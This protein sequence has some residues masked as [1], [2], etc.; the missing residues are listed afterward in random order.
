M[1]R[2]RLGLAPP[3]APIMNATR[4]LEH[5]GVGV[6]ANLDGLDPPSSTDH[7]GISMPHSSTGRPPL[8]ALISELSGAEQRFAL[9]H[10]LG[11]LIFDQGLS[12]PIR[13]R[14][15]PA[16]L[17]AHHFARAM[18][19]PIEAVSNRISETLNLQGYL[20]IKAEFGVPVASIIK[21]GGR[22]LGLISTDRERSLFIQWSSQGWRKNEPSR[23]PQRSPPSFSARR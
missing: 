1:T 13:T 10:E 16:E 21:R 14:R 23:W 17:R 18:L 5:L 4:T 7:M 19:L 3:G 15:H 9:M 2:N 8:V 6:V 20:G 12:A 11:H 22:D